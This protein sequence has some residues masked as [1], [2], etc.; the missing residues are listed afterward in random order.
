MKKEHFLIL[1]IIFNASNFLFAQESY[2]NPE[3]IPVL[4]F[5]TF[6]LTNTTDANSSFVDIKNPEVKRDINRIVQ[7]LI[8][9]KPTIICVEIPKKYSDGANQ[10]YQEYKIDQSKKTN[11]TEE[12]NSIAFEVG[13]LSGVDNIYGIDFPIGFDYPK[14]IE[15]AENS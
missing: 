11:W 9:F 3:W 13:R 6:H 5:A 1:L 7:K 10:I 12:I 4:N 14:L 15:M 2:K 8:E